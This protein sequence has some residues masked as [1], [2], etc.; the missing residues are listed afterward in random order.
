MPFLDPAVVSEREG[1][2]K[3]DRSI[4]EIACRRAGVEMGQAAHVGD[5]YDAY[6]YS[7]LLVM[8]LADEKVVEM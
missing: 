3:P 8:G 5:E 2:E 1:V 6:V 4:W 7:L